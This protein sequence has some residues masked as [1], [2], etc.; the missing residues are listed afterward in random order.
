MSAGEVPVSLTCT[1]RSPLARSGF[2][3]FRYCHTAVFQIC[4]EY[5]RLV[6]D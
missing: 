2:E 5:D 4:S 1:T 3:A 6:S